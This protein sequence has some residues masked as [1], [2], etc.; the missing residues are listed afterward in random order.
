[1]AN[2]SDRCLTCRKA[3]SITK[4][5]W[6]WFCNEPECNYEACETVET[7]I[8]TTYSSNTTEKTTNI[9]IYN[10]DTSEEQNNALQF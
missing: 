2:W 4:W 7:T 5:G 3:G 9:T 6:M 1:M 8:A 10:N